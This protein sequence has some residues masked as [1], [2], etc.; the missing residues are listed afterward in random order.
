M[1]REVLRYST[2]GAFVARIGW[3]TLVVCG[4]IG[5]WVCVVI[6]CAAFSEELPY[7]VRRGSLLS[8]GAAQDV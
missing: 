7:S 2:T 4:V 6:H 1:S 5:R 8:D 3:C